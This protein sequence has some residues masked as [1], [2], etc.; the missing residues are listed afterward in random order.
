MGCSEASDT[1]LDIIENT[2]TNV[3]LATYR[4]SNSIELYKAPPV[5]CEGLISCSSR[6]GEQLIGGG[7]FEAAKLID[8]TSM[9]YQNSSQQEWYC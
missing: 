5:N 6:I 8:L 4:F 9:Q 7:V 2:E 3:D 1:I